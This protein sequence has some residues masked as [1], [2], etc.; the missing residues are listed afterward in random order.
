MCKHNTTLEHR[1]EM[2]VAVCECG[3]EG[4]PRGWWDNY[5]VTDCKLDAAR[6]E[7][8][9]FRAAADAILAPEAA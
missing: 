9:A 6:H 7:A 3:W 1:G 4:R 5:Q 8:E 2:L